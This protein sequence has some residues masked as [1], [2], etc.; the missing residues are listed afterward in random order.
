MVD[1]PESVEIR[2]HLNNGNVEAYV[3]DDPEQVARILGN[4][5]PSRV[6]DTS[7]LTIAGKYSMTAYRC[8]TICLLE[9]VMDFYP[10]WRFPVNI[11]EVREVTEEEFWDAYKPEEDEY[12]V[13]EQQRE[14]GEEF[15][16]FSQLELTSGK[17]LYAR[18]HSVVQPQLDRLHTINHILIADALYARRREGGALVVNLANVARFGFHPGPPDTPKNAWLASHKTD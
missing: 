9:F 6:F 7:H 18:I 10:G 11:E 12:F 4:F 14:V 13:R 15:I 8:S 3:Q 17:S 1:L 5:Q 16:S 2:V